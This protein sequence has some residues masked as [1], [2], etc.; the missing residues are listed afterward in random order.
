[1]TE[2]LDLV[3]LKA[4]VSELLSEYRIPSAAI[5]ILHDADITDFALAS[6]GCHGAT[7]DER[8]YL[9][10]RLHE[11]GG[12]RE[13]QCAT[14]CCIRLSW[15]A[16]RASGEA[17]P[18]QFGESRA[19]VCG[20]VPP[21]QVQTAPSTAVTKPHPTTRSSGHGQSGG[22]LLDPVWHH[23]EQLGLA[24]FRPGVVEQGTAKVPG[25]TDHTAGVDRHGSP[26][27]CNT[28]SWC[29]SPCSTTLPGELAQSCPNSAAGVAAPNGAQRS[30][31]RQEALG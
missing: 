1:M 14:D 2:Q 16:V 3:K 12:E 11:C 22:E 29:R 28:L 23:C 4:W 27:A 20:I 7:R 26:V 17:G 31:E 15:E 21:W 8:H 18:E 25:V 30:I 19:R 9:P 13:E 6:R 10:M 5:G 24:A